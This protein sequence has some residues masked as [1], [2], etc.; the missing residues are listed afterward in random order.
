MPVKAQ[1]KYAELYNLMELDLPGEFNDTADYFLK[2]N[3]TEYNS[4]V[5]SVMQFKD[6]TTK[7]VKPVKLSEHKKTIFH[8]VEDYLYKN[9][10]LRFNTVLL[11]IEMK[12]KNSKEWKICNES[13]LYVEMQ[14]KGIN[15]QMAK[16]IAILK[17]DFVPEFNPILN[18]FKANSKW[19]CND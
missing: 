3:K 4:L 19:D 5:E 18:Y 9:Y 15:I 16:L 13:S 6:N 2:H 11:D 14:K 8:I 1:K 10:D 12:Q 7:L 17:S